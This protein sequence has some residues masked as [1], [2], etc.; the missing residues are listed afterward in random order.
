[1]NVAYIR[2][3]TIE[4]NEARQL[5]AMKD[6]HIEKYFTEKV[7]AKNTNRPK[8]QE[9]LD[10]VREGDTIYIHDFSRL[11]R[12]TEDL[13]NIVN[14]LND[15]GVH[16]VSNKENL[17]TSTP[18]GKLLLTMIG[19]IAQFEREN[20]LERQREGIKIAKEQGKFKGGQPKAIDKELFQELKEKYNRREINKVQ[21]AKLL[22]VS[23]PTLDKLLA[24]E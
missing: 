17:D 19:A 8:L 4:Q 9:M 23:R 20:L 22:N 12:S 6:K 21:F 18:T 2:V 16:L 5:E 13:L 24:A 14:Q 11:A 1:M 10:F 7:S 15:K 3:S